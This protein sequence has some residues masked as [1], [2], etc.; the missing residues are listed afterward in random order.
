[1]QRLSQRLTQALAHFRASSYPIGRNA[2]G[3][4]FQKC[5]LRIGKAAESFNIK[6]AAKALCQTSHDF[7]WIAPEQP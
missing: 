3:S 4:A 5:N 2:G 7:G 1:V 6:I